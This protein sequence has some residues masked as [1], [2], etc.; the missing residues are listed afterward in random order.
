MSLPALASGR[1]PQ[2]W[3]R[4]ASRHEIC[5]GAFQRAASALRA[6]PGLPVTRRLSGGPALWIAPGT[7]HLLLT[8]P[9]PSALI[10]DADPHRLI[11]RHVR[12][13][14][15][16]LRRVGALASYPGRDWVSASHRPVAWV[17]LA[18]HAASGACAFEAFIPLLEPFALPAHLDGYPA[19]NNAPFLGKTPASLGQITSRPVPPEQLSDALLAA[20]DEVGG[21]LARPPWTDEITRPLA[22][23]TRPPWASLREGVI[24]FL[25]ASREP[26]PEL[27][28]DFFAS[29]DLIDAINDALA[30]RPPAPCDDDLRAALARAVGS[31]EGGIF[32]G[33]RSV[34]EIVAVL[35]AAAG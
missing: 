8:L 14:L 13:L 34:D 28:G 2:I 33:I 27:G 18:H 12:P 30:A 11:N 20:Y 24:G 10:A 9:S 7:L 16:A 29:S 19:R 17:G 4:T 22:L 1:S 3:L 5:L 35:G 25:G 23:D 31:V 6:S 15:R 21:P 32:E 26:A